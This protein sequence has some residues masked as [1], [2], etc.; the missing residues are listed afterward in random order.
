MKKRYNESLFRKSR[1]NYN[2]LTLD[3]KD[4]YKKKTKNVLTVWK[5]SEEILWM[6]GGGQTENI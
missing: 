2:K 4:R 1:H 3:A 5:T 6:I